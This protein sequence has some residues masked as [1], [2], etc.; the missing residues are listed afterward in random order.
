MTWKFYPEEWIECMP[1]TTEFF[2]HTTE[3][4]FFKLICGER[5]GGGMSRDVY[6]FGPDFVI[7]F[8]YGNGFFQNIMEWETWQEV[9][10]TEFA[11]WF[12]P[13]EKISGTGIVLIQRRTKPLK[14]NKYPK[15]MPAF[16][17]DFKHSN[18]GMY[19]GHLVAHD[20][21]RTR[22]MTAGLTKRMVAA[23]WTHD[24]ES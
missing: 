22:L 10:E 14:A 7:K 2:Q 19:K 8:E 23:N 11:P 6:E 15:D 4:D 20:Y 3:K 16:L 13:C 21:G 5:L 12:A 18:Y 17:G 1:V 24:L 9:K